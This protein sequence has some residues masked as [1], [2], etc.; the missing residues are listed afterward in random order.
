M[1]ALPKQAL[2]LLNTAKYGRLSKKMMFMAVLNPHIL[3]RMLFG[4]E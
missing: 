3:L 2:M 1:N 4:Q